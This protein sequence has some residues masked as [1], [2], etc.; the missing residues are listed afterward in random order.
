MAWGHFYRC[1]GRGGSLYTTGIL[2]GMSR[3]LTVRVA[4][5]STGIQCQCVLMVCICVECTH[6]FREFVVVALCDSMISGKL[7]R[8]CVYILGPST[9]Y[10]SS[11]NLPSKYDHHVLHMGCLYCMG[12]YKWP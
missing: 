11:H 6:T 5:S 1:G 12:A 10:S 4:C 7:I 2:I 8:E 9:A 3:A